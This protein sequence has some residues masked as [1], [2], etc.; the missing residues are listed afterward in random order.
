MAVSSAKW[1]DQSY[2]ESMPNSEVNWAQLAQ[3]WMAMRDAGETP[4]DGSLPPPPPPPSR[5][6][7]R[8]MQTLDGNFAHSAPFFPPLPIDGTPFPPGHPPP[9]WMPPPPNNFGSPVGPYPPFMPPIPPWTNEGSSMPVA[10]QPPLQIPQPH[11]SP[12]TD[13]PEQ[14]EEEG[15][16]YSHY[17]KEWDEKQRAEMGKRD[18]DEEPDGVPQ[19]AMA[20][21]LGGQW[22]Q[23]PW[24]RSG[25]SN[26]PSHGVHMPYIDQQTRK[27]LPAWIREGL[28]KAEQEK[29]KKLLKEAKLRA[30]EEARKARREAK[31]L[32]KFDSDSSEDE[33][34]NEGGKN[35]SF[36]GDGEPVFL[37]AKQEADRHADHKEHLEVDY[38]TEEEKR[39]DA[40]T[41]LRRFM[42]E[43]LM[44]T[45]DAQLQQIC[46]EQFNSAMRKAAQPK[47]LVKSSALAALCTLGAGSDSE[48]SDGEEAAQRSSGMEADDES[49]EQLRRKCEEAEDASGAKSK[50]RLSSHDERTS[51]QHSQPAGEVVRKEE[52]QHEETSKC[53]RGVIRPEGW[54]QQT[55]LTDNQKNNNSSPEGNKLPR[56]ERDREDSSSEESS[57]KRKRKK[58]LKVEEKGKTL[59]L[60]ARLDKKRT[61]SRKRDGPGALSGRSD[62]SEGQ[63]ALPPPRPN[64]TQ[65]KTVMKAAR[66]S[67]SLEHLS[68]I[69]E[70]RGAEA[71]VAERSTVIVRIGSFRIRMHIPR[72]DRTRK[73]GREAERDV[74]HAVEAPLAVEDAP[75]GHALDPKTALPIFLQLVIAEFF[76]YTVVVAIADE[77]SS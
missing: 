71:K 15:G 12:H 55:E 65:M 43:I 18:T 67:P 6:A 4:N 34:S 45:T 22:N 40:L 59:P 5:G 20:H 74:V 61:R 1:M 66:A 60:D 76:V 16:E 63:V 46:A 9:G 52:E 27:A 2:Y 31:G 36:T 13:E 44:V 75:D 23:P 64:R 69:G 42:T 8:R 68:V 25:I 54:N 50:A 57:L 17:Y 73:G 11:Y 30:A 21:W 77:L 3:N 14:E 10:P 32:G 19:G 56:N 62:R 29:Q 24:F 72:T 58:A 35:G 51:L 37:K 39:E 53:E 49:G 70:G 48:E 47:V 33:S 7:G 28:E 38:R 26:G 41:L